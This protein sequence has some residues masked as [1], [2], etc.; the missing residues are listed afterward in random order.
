[1]SIHDSQLDTSLLKFH[2]YNSSQYFRF[3]YIMTTFKLVCTSNFDTTFIW[4][5]YWQTHKVTLPINIQNML[6]FYSKLLIQLYW[7]TYYVGSL[8]GGSYHN[9]HGL[10]TSSARCY[11]YLNSN[12]RD[13]ALWPVTTV[14]HQNRGKR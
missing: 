8:T 6:F 13:D 7:I 1:M 4:L 12:G 9:S 11:W 14:I 2:I 10:V 3:Q 5:K